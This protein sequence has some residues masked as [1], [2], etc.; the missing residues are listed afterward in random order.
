[1]SQK[2]DTTIHQA[3]VNLL[4]P[5]REGRSIINLAPPARSPNLSQFETKRG[6]GHDTLLPR[7]RPSRSSTLRQYHGTYPDL[8]KYVVEIS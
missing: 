4:V 2:G 1:M 3:S 5:A 6:A 8:M 7:P